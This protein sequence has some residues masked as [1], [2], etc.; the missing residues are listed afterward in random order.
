MSDLIEFLRAR[1]NE[2]ERAAVWAMQG[3]WRLHRIPA[4]SAWQITGTSGTHSVARI[5]DSGQNEGTVR[6]IALH[7]PARVLREVEAKR[8]IVERHQLGSWHSHV[9]DADVKTC[10]ACGTPDEDWPCPD[11]RLL[12]LPYSD[13]PDYREDWRP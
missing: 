8:A 4:D 2:D 6:H 9:L 7:D 1:L 13:H 12:A 11:L 10:R 3:P 5:P